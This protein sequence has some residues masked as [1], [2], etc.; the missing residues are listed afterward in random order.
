MS[1]EQTIRAAENERLKFRKLIAVP[2]Y[3]YAV[4]LGRV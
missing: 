1:P 3:H 2:P 4:V